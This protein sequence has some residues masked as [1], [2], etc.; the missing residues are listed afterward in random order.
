MVW[1][2]FLLKWTFP[3]EMIQKWMFLFWN[4]TQK[5]QKTAQEPRNIKQAEVISLHWKISSLV[6]RKQ[7]LWNFIIDKNDLIRGRYHLAIT[8][9]SHT[10]KPNAQRDS[11]KNHTCYKHTLY[12]PQMLPFALKTAL[13]RSIDWLTCSH[14]ETSHTARAAADVYCM[15]GSSLLKLTAANFPSLARRLRNKCDLTAVFSTRVPSQQQHQSRVCVCVC[16]RRRQTLI[17]LTSSWVSE[18]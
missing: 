5:K 8:L 11:I 7:G 17:A 13:T 16:V 9:K 1:F 15:T 18:T 10:L 3:Q 12:K 4:N 2:F 14:W 6:L